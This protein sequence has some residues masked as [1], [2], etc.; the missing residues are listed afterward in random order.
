[1]C[2]CHG[3][4]LEKVVFYCV[5]QLKRKSVRTNDLTSMRRTKKKSYLPLVFAHECPFG[6]QVDYSAILERKMYLLYPSWILLW[7]TVSTSSAVLMI[8]RLIM[9]VQTLKA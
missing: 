4:S 8:V 9:V 2:V 6:E 5:L 3:D 7:A 1:M